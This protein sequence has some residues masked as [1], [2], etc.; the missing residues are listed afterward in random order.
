MLLVRLRSPG[1]NKRQRDGSRTIYTPLDG[2]VVGGAPSMP[3]R[4]FLRNHVS[5][6]DTTA[7][8]RKV[9]LQ[10][11]GSRGPSRG[12]QGAGLGGRLDA[13][14]QGCVAGHSPT[15]TRLLK[16][17]NRH[18]AC[19]VR[20]E[21]RASRVGIVCGHCGVNRKD[22]ARE[23]AS[24]YFVGRCD[25]EILSNYRATGSSCPFIRLEQARGLKRQETEDCRP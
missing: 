17:P 9:R 15:P 14:R 19:S 13:E 23:R 5:H 18:P 3:S 16:P 1:R 6:A 4:P 2:P 11:K 22:A 25:Q 7:R 21:T 20:P 12:M 24:G 10:G 8:R